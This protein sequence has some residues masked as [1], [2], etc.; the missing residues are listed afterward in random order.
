MKVRDLIVKMLDTELVR[1]KDSYSKKTIFKGYS[2]EVPEE[3]KGMEVSLFY[4]F[5]N[6]G[7][8]DS[9]IAIEVEEA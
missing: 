3:V 8:E 4:S 2:D 1:I 6:P 7:A 5:V 9:F